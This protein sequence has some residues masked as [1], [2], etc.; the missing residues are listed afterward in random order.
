MG[1]EPYGDSLTS[2]RRTRNRHSVPVLLHRTTKE[3]ETIMS[4]RL[5]HRAAALLVAVTVGATGAHVSTTYTR[6]DC[7]PVTSGTDA[8]WA[9][10]FADGWHGVDTDG[11][12]A[13]YPPHCD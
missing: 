4:I 10:L 3:Q 2:A 6:E 9:E 1:D 7:H 13:L 12:E 11:M 8:E 5:R